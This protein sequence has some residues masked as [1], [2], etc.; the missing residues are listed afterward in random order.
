ML[1]I[2]IR[3][4]KETVASSSVNIAEFTAELSGLP[5]KTRGAISLSGPVWCQ[6]RAV[7]RAPLAQRGNIH[8]HSERCRIP[9]CFLDGQM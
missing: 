2:R 8:F 5:I 1:R 6:I 7:R 3:K 9:R 4:R